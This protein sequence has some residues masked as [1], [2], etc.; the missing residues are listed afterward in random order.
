MA[1]ARLWTN[2]IF[3][4][5][6]GIR[7]PNISN[8]HWVHF[9]ES[10]VLFFR[11]SYPHTFGTG[12]VPE[13]MSSISAEIAYSA[14]APLDKASAVQRT[15]DDLRRVGAMAKDDEVVVTA[16]HDIPFAYCVY[17]LERKRSLHLIRDWLRSVDIEP[18]GRYG[19]WTYFWSDEAMLSGKKAA[20][21]VL[22]AA[23]RTAQ[24]S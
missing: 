16:T 6:L 4:V 22:Q 5:N 9:P 11:I 12:V 1:A 15:I 18:T 20:E 7:R 3:V 21:R 24:V 8:R 14:R 2:S 23:E 19:L 10:D 17:D 13:G